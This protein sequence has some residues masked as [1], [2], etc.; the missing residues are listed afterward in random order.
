[1]EYSKFVTGSKL[2]M[3]QIKAM[4]IKKFLYSIRN[5]ILL[6]IQ[7]VIPALF[8]VITMLGEST[9]TGDK[10]LP[11]LSIAFD[12]YLSTVTTVQKGTFQ[13]GSLVDNIFKSYQNGFSNL[14]E[15]HSLSVTDNDFQDEIL[16]QYRA[17]M[18]KTNL[19]YMVGATFSDGMIKAWF[20]N[21]GY[22]TAPLT[23]NLINNAILK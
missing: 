11:Q 18:S 16:N 7:F 17:S 12:E 21:Q 3:S 5:Y 22:H 23:V 9:L 1:M 19:N 10:D 14:P 8:I 20:N 6:I 4:T 15:E 2:H 13:E